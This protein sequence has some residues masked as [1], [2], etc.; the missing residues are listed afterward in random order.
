MVD[1][2]RYQAIGPDSVYAQELFETEELNGY[3]DKMVEVQ[4]SLSDAIRYDSTVERTFAETLNANEAV[5]VF[6]KLP[7]WFK[8]PTPLGSY[9]P[10]WAVLL[11]SEAGD[12][13]YFVVETKGTQ[14]LEDLRASEADKIQCGAKHFRAIA[15]AD[16]EPEFLQAVTAE[17]VL[18]R[19]AT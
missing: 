19:A 18:Q 11:T 4:K 3:L 10:D 12:R 15:R 16:K 13:L 17:Q 6:A 1:G 9:N 14:F 2:V 5:K 7:D 8:V